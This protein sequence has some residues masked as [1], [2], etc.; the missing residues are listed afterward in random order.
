MISLIKVGIEP[1]A[2]MGKLRLW[3][4]T[5]PGSSSYEMSAKGPEPPCNSGDHLTSSFSALLAPPPSFL[6]LGHDL[7]GSLSSSP[8]AWLLGRQGSATSRL[9]SDRGTVSRL[10]D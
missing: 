5:F 3:G 6:Y 10:T 7:P 4:V 8:H 1:I 9:C 2:Q